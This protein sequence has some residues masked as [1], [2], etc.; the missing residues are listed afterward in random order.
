MF[1]ALI[2]LWQQ[3]AI[4]RKKQCPPG[5]LCFNSGFCF[6]HALTRKKG[7]ERGKNVWRNF[8]RTRAEPTELQPADIPHRQHIPFTQ[9]E[10]LILLLGREG[11]KGGGNFGTSQSANEAKNICF[12]S[13]LSAGR[14]GK[15]RLLLAAH[16]QSTFM[17]RETYLFKWTWYN[18]SF[19]QNDL[20]ARVMNQANY[21]WPKS[22][23]EPL[24]PH[25]KLMPDL[26]INWK[27]R[28]GSKIFRHKLIC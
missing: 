8:L 13:L 3:I 2:R 27:R 15:W 5:I 1:C 28:K 20:Q 4:W 6:Q 19:A 11:G 22:H 12:V 18:Q 10:W 26:L 21:F 23:I 24:I 7:R 16:C 9:N 25:P 14:P 17:N